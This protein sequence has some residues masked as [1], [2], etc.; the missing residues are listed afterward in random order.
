MPGIYLHYNQNCLGY[1]RKICLLL[2]AVEIGLDRDASLSDQK[3]QSAVERE[4]L[5]ISE[6]CR[7]I[8]H[9]ESEQNVPS[10]NRLA[11][12]F[13]RIPWHQ[14][15][16]MGNLLRHEYGRVDSEIIWATATGS[17]LPNLSVPA[18]RAL[19]DI[20]VA[21]Y[22]DALAGNLQPARDISAVIGLQMPGAYGATRWEPAR[23]LRN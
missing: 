2:K 8:N 3:T 22:R 6:A 7:G 13:P 9:L 19:D 10:K 15:S 21:P 23:H 16:A 20:S 14:I 1:A 4:L 12:R 11:R 17:D 5:T 18:A